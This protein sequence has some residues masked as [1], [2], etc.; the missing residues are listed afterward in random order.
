MT[1][2][3][4]RKGKCRMLLSFV[5]KPHKLSVMTLWR[6]C[7]SFTIAFKK[8]VIAFMNE[9]NSPYRAWKYFSNRD[10]TEHDNSIFHQWKKRRE[11]ISI[12]GATKKRSVGRGRKLKLE[13]TEDILVD[14]IVNLQLQKLKVTRT[15]IR[16]RAKQM[17][18]E[19]NIGEEFKASS[20]W[21]TLYL[22]RNGFSL[23]RTT[24]LT[25]LTDDQLIQQAVDYVKYLHVS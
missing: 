10:N 24:N 21:A 6:K 23:R 17:A 20:H 18:E 2:T 7:A 5:T 1:A 12:T 15:F 3:K 9:G 4:V 11:D 22:R 19:A 13:D 14:E 25:T 8:E 16:E